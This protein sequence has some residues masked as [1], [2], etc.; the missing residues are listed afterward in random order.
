[1][2]DV[3]VEAM[4]AAVDMA[5]R[6]AETKLA[7]M[8]AEIEA[9]REES[10]A[11]GILQKISYDNA[12]NELLKYAML[13]QIK[14]SKEYKKDGMTWE[15]FCEAAG[16]NVR[17]VHRVLKDLKPVYDRFSDNLSC[18]LS[19]PLNKI[20]YLGKEFSDNLSENKDGHLILGEEKIPLTPDNKDEIEAAIDTLIE[21]HKKEK[22][23]LKKQVKRYKNQSDKVVAEEV[24]GL[25]AERDALVKEVARLKEF[26]PAE[27]DISWAEAYLAELKDLVAQFEVGVRRMVMD[28]RLH[29]AMDLQAQCQV[30]ID[31]MVRQARGLQQD[32]DAEFNTVDYS[33]PDVQY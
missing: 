2:K 11:L 14:Q 20:R 26:D 21:S 31:T 3:N 25:T 16:E 1:M 32:W 33:D 12:H 29:E 24:K 23:T 19:V 28:E 5:T 15:Q 8:E 10:R 27:K 4:N 9:I 7:R 22:Q 18:F 6:E 30:F 17:N 13:Y